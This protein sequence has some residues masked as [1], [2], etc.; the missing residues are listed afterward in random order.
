MRLPTYEVN[1]IALRT[2]SRRSP[3][4]GPNDTSSWSSISRS[5]ASSTALRSRNRTIS[6]YTSIPA[7]ASSVIG[8]PS[9]QGWWMA[10]RSSSVTRL[11]AL[12]SCFLAF[13][14]TLAFPKR[15]SDRLRVCARLLVSLAE[16]AVYRVRTLYFRLLRRLHHRSFQILISLRILSRH[17]AR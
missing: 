4:S 8:W 6:S 14:E 9:L 15:A 16:A 13:V 12:L 7:D 3:V 11:M 5:N 2:R 1:F 17:A 10:C